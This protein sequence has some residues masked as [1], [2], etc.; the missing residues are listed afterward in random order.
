MANLAND[1]TEVGQTQHR[2]PEHRARFYRDTAL[3]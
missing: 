2:L 1:V 3:V